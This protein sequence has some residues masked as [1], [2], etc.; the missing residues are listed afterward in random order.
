MMKKCQKGIAVLLATLLFLLPGCGGESSSANSGTEGGGSTTTS[1]G[2]ASQQSSGAGNTFTFV[3]SSE[4]TTLDA[5]L[6]PGPTEGRIMRLINETLYYRDENSEVHPLLAESAESSEDRMTWT[7]HLKQGIKF[8]D[9]TPFNAEA[10]KFSFDRLLDPETASP[11]AS[12]LSMVEETNVVDEYTV[13][14]KLNSPNWI[15]LAT[16]SNYTTA[17]LSPTAV[18]KYGL[19]QY[20]Q[21][22]VGTGPMKLEKWDR[23]LEMSLV[24]N[25]DYWGEPATVDRLIVKWA[26]E[27][28]T[29]VMMMQSGDA[30]VA[31]NIPPIQVA[32]LEADDNIEVVKVPGYRTISVG[33]NVAAEPLNDERVRLAINYAL[34]KQTIIDNVLSG[35]ALYPSGFWS[36]AVEYSAKDLDAHEQNLEK[37]RE[38]LAE[39]GYPD[40]FTVKLTGSEG[41]FA[42]DRQVTEV[43]QAMLSEV[44]IHAEVEILDSAAHTEALLTHNTQLFI[45][46]KG[47]STGDPE[48]D[49]QLHLVTDGGQNFYNYSDP[50]TDKMILEDLPNAADLEEREGIIYEITKRFNDQS[51]VV[52]LYYE[53]QLYAVRSDVEGFVCY[54][55]ELAELAYMTRTES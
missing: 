55:N 9:G 34:G 3:T 46:G 5:H 23:G 42:M 7:I 40:G 45:F 33:M 53:V 17:I 14:V 21:N 8:H 26:P 25:E 10:V 52:P 15:F 50:E 20:G 30:D 49:M 1:E 51:V 41:K 12:A 18:E 35:Q 11:K 4:P 39:A 19:D 2:E 43:V 36:P 37:A 32:N 38:L 47:C 16:L 44:G 6:C 24:K 54:P 48:Y 27:D 28:S 31:S 13:E 22:P 29:R